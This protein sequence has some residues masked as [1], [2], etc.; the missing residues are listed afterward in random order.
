[1]TI[2]EKLIALSRDAIKK[3]VIFL[4]NRNRKDTLEYQVKLDK[5]K[6]GDQEIK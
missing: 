5:R 4:D 3:I 2:K 6:K 1:M